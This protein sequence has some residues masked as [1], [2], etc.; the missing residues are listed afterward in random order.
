M[1]QRGRG[2]AVALSANSCRSSG[3]G[4]A[5]RLPAL[6]LVCRPHL[7]QSLYTVRVCNKTTHYTLLHVE[8][9]RSTITTKKN[10]EK[11]HTTMTLLRKYSFSLSLSLFR[12]NTSP[13]VCGEKREAWVSPAPRR[14]LFISRY[15]VKLY[16]I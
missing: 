13:N 6:Y 11:T 9:E 3:R 5:S 4:R 10:K 15:H 12:L 7:A 16:L 8:G 1:G 2:A 14:N